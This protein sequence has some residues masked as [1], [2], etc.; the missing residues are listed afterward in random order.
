MMRALCVRLV[1]LACSQQLV[2]HPMSH[3][4]LNAERSLVRVQISFRQVEVWF[5][6]A[7][8]ETVASLLWSHFCVLPKGV[9]SFAVWNIW[10]SFNGGHIF[11]LE[12]T[13]WSAFV[14]LHFSKKSVAQLVINLDPIVRLTLITLL[15]RRREGRGGVNVQQFVSSPVAILFFVGQVW[16]TRTKLSQKST[17]V[18]ERQQ[19]HSLPRCAFSVQVN[20]KVQGIK[21]GQRRISGG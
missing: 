4:I 13:L 1:L 2:D 21:I 19:S 20:C 11:L 12:Y 15:D 14:S 6:S 18:N 17:F 9:N 10:F 5:L 16:Q 7:R 8:K 3:V